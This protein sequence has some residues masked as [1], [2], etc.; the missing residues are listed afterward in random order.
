M[1][2]QIPGRR[3]QEIRWTGYTYDTIRPS[4]FEPRARLDGIRTVRIVGTM[5]E[6]R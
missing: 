3:Y 5:V 6:A 1:I 4:C 2:R